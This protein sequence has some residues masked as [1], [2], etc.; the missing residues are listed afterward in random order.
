V[1]VHEQRGRRIPTAQF[2][3]FI[4]TAVT[5]HP[6]TEHG[7][8]LK[9]LYA[10]QASTHPPTFVLFVNDPELVHFSYKR[11]IENQIRRQF[12]FEGSGIRLVFRGRAE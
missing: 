4:R 7:R 8:M 1:A 9:V 11:Y 6:Q 3:E 10:T 12:G 2:N 5:T